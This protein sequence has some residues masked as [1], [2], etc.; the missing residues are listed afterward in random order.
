MFRRVGRT[1]FTNK[2]MCSSA[3]VRSGMCGQQRFINLHT[4]S[5]I[6]GFR[7][8]SHRALQVSSRPFFMRG[9]EVPVHLRKK[10]YNT[11]DKVF[12]GIFA[13]NTLVWVGWQTDFLENALPEEYGS[14]AKELQTFLEG[15]FTL[16]EEGIEKG[17]WY[18]KLPSGWFY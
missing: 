13:V 17:R 9:S 18:T 8:G 6:N 14:R 3:S 15:N 10:V 7:K 11:W 4:T 2:L 16:S 12:A 1:V 5:K